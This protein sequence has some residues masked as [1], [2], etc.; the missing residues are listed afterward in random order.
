M[1]PLLRAELRHGWATWS[2]LAA[3]GAVAAVSFSAAIAMLEAGLAEGGEI[4]D[5]SVSFLSILLILNVPAGAIVIAAVSRL[6]VGLHRAVYARWQ[7]A[8]VSPAQTSAVVISQLTGVGLLAG[9]VGFGAAVLIVPPFLHAVFV[10]DSSWWAEASIRPGALTGVIVVPLTT[11]VVLLG[12]FRG[13][14]SAG[15]TP[16]LSALREP[17]AEA[18]RMRW[19]RWLLLVAV[20]L[21]AGFGGALAPFRA[22]ERSTA[23]SQFPLLPAYLTAIV[24]TAA[25]VLSPLV[26]RAWTALIPARASATWHLAR[27][28]ARYHLG[29]S[30]ASVT[31]LFVGT[32]LLGGLM[33][34]SATTS[35]AMTSAGLPGNFDLGIMQVMLLV[36]G[37]VLLGATGAAVVLFMSNRTQASEQALLRASGASH[38]VVLGAAVCQAAIHVITATLLASIVVFGTALIS[39]AALG[40]FVP[41]VPVLDIGAAAQLVALGLVLTVSATLV[42]AMARM[43]EPL[44]LRLAAE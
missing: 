41:A 11:L 6:A 18:K 16:A 19:W 36:G 13:A 7:L 31:P 40:R 39:A 20:L 42:P 38:G 24:A 43:R 10:D 14:R 23:I 5:A 35:T 4:L 25:P 32:A 37:P 27:H 2:G 33:T 34:M 26:L 21:A 9:F 15:R 22:E 1:I 12:G 8:G 29:R 30:T 17:E 44:A 3:V 28:Q